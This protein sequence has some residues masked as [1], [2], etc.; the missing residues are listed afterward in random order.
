MAVALDVDRRVGAVDERRRGVLEV[1]EAV[2][3]RVDLAVDRGVDVLVRD[4]DPQAVVT[5]ELDD[6]PDLDDRI[7]LDVAGLFAGCDIDLRRRNRVEVFRLDGLAVV[8][9]QLVAERLLTCDL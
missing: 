1:S 5:L 7:E 2:A 3:Q 4:L 8:V 9:R 6:G